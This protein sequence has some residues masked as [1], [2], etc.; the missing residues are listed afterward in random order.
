[1]NMNRQPHVVVIGG[2]FGGLAVAKHLAKVPVQ[3]TL[4]DRRNHHLFQPLLYQVATAALNPSDIAYPI[5]AAL[6]K[7]KNVR[8]LLAEAKSI[9]VDKRIVH[10]DDGELEYDFVVVATGAT[11]SYFGNGAWAAHAPGLKS[12]EDALEIRRRIFLAYEAAERESDAVAQ[13]EWLTF[14]VVGGGPTG[15]E[16]AGALGEIGLTTLAHDFRTIDPT[17]VRVLLF[18]GRERVLTAY[19]PKISDAAKASLEK[20]HVEVRIN[21]RVTQIDATGVTVKVA[22]REERIGVRTV[23]WAA[24]V[25]ASPLA[26]SLGVPLDRSGRV[27]VRPDLSIPHHPEVFVIGD[28]AKMISKG[29]EVPGVAQGALQ[30]GAH[31]AKVIAAELANKPMRTEFRYWDKGNMATI[32]RAS[33]VVATKRVA[34]SGLFAWLMWWAVH[35]FYLVGYRNR[36]LVLGHWI[37]S[38]ITFRRGARLITGDTGHLPAVRTIGPDGMVRLPPGASEVVSLRAEQGERA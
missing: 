6:A 10:L 14:A 13:R 12:V 28:L 11:H 4:I 26:K 36:F 35:I 16:L 5:R 22:D 20:R 38:W 2:G 8:V 33:A 18:E 21:S 9:D 23:L 29:E 7:Q 24:G 30:G 1:M 34:I 37:W 31:V 19:P 15:V 32:G 25:Q 17:G 27:E 3:I